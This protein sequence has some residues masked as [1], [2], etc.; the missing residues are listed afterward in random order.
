VQQDSARVD[1]D[2]AAWFFAEYRARP[3]PAFVERLVERLQLSKQDRVLDLGAGAGAIALWLAPSVGEVVAVDQ[4]ADLLAEGA[5]RAARAGADNVR[6]IQGGPRELAKLALYGTFKIATLGLASPWLTRPDDLIAGLAPVLDES[7]GAL[8]F[9]GSDAENPGSIG[10]AIEPL[11][12]WRTRLAQ[13]LEQFSPGSLASARAET[14]RPSLNELFAHSAFA[15]VERLRSEYEAVEQPCLQ[16][17]IGLLYSYAGVLERLGH[18]RAVFERV[19][20]DELGW[21][22]RLPKVSAKRADVA[23]LARRAD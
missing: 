19:A 18:R 13:L 21:V 2:S 16:S 9:L 3:H 10:G 15:R 12:G 23:V 6:F 20:K 1:A 17:A 11:Y 22:D 4:R 5:Q 7:E 14:L 8:A